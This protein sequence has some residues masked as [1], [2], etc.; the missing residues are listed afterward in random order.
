MT[1]QKPSQDDRQED[2]FDDPDGAGIVHRVTVEYRPRTL[3]HGIGVIK[4]VFNASGYLLDPHSAIGFEAGRQC[5][6]NPATPM[7]TLATAHPAKFPQ[8]VMQ[9]G[10]SEEP[11]LPRYMADLYQRQERFSVLDGKLASVQEFMA[12]NISGSP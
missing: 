8:A 1:D 11:E 2:L 5:R 6:R 7:I 10:Q 4:E 12:N 9:A 3:K